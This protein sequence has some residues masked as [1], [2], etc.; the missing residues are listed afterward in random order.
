[1]GTEIA[2]QLYKEKILTAH[3]MRNR[4]PLE[5]KSYLWNNGTV[6][7]ILNNRFYLGKMS[8]GKS[9][10]KSVGSHAGISV[11]KEDGKVIPHHH[12]VLIS[13]ETFEMVS[14]FK[15]GQYSKRIGKRHPLVGKLFCGSYGYA[16]N[17]KRANKNTN[18]N[19]F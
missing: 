8:C 2:K 17:Y 12:T 9:I 6:R 15:A 10:R 18:V 4:K 13:E 14:R 16:M 19:Y 3:Q 7:N 5:G 11:T 1:M